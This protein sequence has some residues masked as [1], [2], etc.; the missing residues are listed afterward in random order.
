MNNG[1][2]KEI[3]EIYVDDIIPNRFQPRLAFDEKSL[4]DLAG[5]IK[6]HGIIQP[7]VLRKIGDKYEIIAGE[8]RYKAAVMVGLKKVPAVLMNLDDNQSAEI[9]VVENTQRKDLTPLEEA[10]SYKKLLDRRYLT[11]EQLA[12]RMGKSQSYISNKL[13]LLNLDEEVQDALLN[14]RI[15]E[16]H[17][18][19]LLSLSS[20]EQQKDVLNQIINGKLTVKQTDSLIKDLTGNVPPSEDNSGDVN[21]LTS[22]IIN[23]PTQETIVSNPIHIDGLEP[24]NSVN[25]EKEEAIDINPVREQPNLDQL[26]NTNPPAPVEEPKNDNQSFNQVPPM[27][28]FVPPIA[29]TVNNNKFINPIDMEKDETNMSMGDIL[30]PEAKQEPVINNDFKM[31]EESNTANDIETNPIPAAETYKMPETSAE[32]TIVSPAPLD[33]TNMGSII[34]EYRDS[35]QSIVPNQDITPG[36]LNSA[37]T[38]I[39]NAGKSLEKAGFILDIEEFDFEQLYQMIIKI[40]KK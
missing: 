7:L 19:S 23:I 36:N 21:T 35:K 27:P 5:S 12:T 4:Q 30:T 34:Q 38:Y 16:R 10:K 39:R 6:E 15:S 18:R 1:M 28:A 2:E 24:I 32:P 37:I 8:R 20:P 40:Q 33:N 26:L 31:E 9:A 25:K 13:R 3:F 14:E 22:P 29:E 17:A 11:Q